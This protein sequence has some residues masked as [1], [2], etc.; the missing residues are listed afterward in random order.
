MQAAALS[1]Y[2][3]SDPA[4]GRTA[5]EYFRLQN[6][7]VDAAWDVSSGDDR[8]RLDAL[9]NAPVPEETRRARL[10]LQDRIAATLVDPAAA[11]ALN[12]VVYMFHHPDTLAA[13]R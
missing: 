4:L 7:V 8:A 12:D 3:T 2:L 5:I 13:W 9:T 11:R 10:A 6:V 1:L